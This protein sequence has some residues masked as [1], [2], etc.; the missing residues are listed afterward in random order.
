MRHLHATLLLAAGV[1]PKVAQERLGHASVTLTLNTYSHVI[2]TIA[3]D[4]ASR[5][6]GVVFG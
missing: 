6:G 3:S 4:A 1:H 2:P 5:F